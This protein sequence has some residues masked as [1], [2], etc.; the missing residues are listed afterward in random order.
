[1]PPVVSP[2]VQAKID[3]VKPAAVERSIIQTQIWA[4][5]NN[6]AVVNDTRST[7]VKAFEAEILRNGGMNK[8]MQLIAEKVFGERVNAVTPQG[9]TL[10]P[11]FSSAFKLVKP[12]WDIISEMF[13]GI[14]PFGTVLLTVSSG[15]GTYRSA[16]GKLHKISPVSTY[17]QPATDAEIATLLD[18]LFA[19]RPAATLK[20]FGAPMDSKVT[21]I[22]SEEE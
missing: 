16:D 13:A 3:L 5:L 12:S 8:A 1:M 6:I 22:L 20:L 10:T 11:V 7:E 19:V 2:V 18:G 4:E 21:S 17:V 9:H 15:K 14:I